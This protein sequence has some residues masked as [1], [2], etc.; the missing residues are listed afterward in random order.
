MP[1][2]PKRSIEERNVSVGFIQV[3]RNPLRSYSESW[4]SLND[5]DFLKQMFDSGIAFYTYDGCPMVDIII[6][7]RI[8]SDDVGNIDGFCYVPMLVAIQWK[9]GIDK[10]HSETACK[11]MKDQAIRDGLDRA[12]CLLIVFGSEAEAKPFEGDIAI[13]RDSTEVSDKLMTGIVA[14]AIRVPAEDA[15]GLA[16]AFDARIPK[17]SVDDLLS[18]HPY[19]K[20]HGS[21]IATNKGECFNDP[22]F[23]HSEEDRRLFVNYCEHVMKGSTEGDSSLGTK[24]NRTEPLPNEKGKEKGKKDDSS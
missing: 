24:S 10:S 5:Q 12:L 16:A 20:A 18:Y 17:Q 1:C 9:G 15:F 3:C 19:L 8:K 14:K 21:D 6:P 11:E 22:F 13:K 2:D 4:K 7:L 23:F